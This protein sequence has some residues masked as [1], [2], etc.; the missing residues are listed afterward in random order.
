MLAY[1]IQACAKR[2]A[3]GNSCQTETSGPTSQITMSVIIE[4]RPPIPTS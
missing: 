2:V 1:K 4:S 3:I